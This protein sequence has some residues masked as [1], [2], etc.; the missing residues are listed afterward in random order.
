[1]QNDIYYFNDL[2]EW[3]VFEKMRKKE[4]QTELNYFQKSLD[5]SS[6]SG[7]HM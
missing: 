3:G 6:W 1:M 2:F 4:R 5:C 7:L